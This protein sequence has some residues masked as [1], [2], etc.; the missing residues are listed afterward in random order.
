MTR[1]IYEQ[2]ATEFGLAARISMMDVEYGLWTG[3]EAYCAVA[4]RDNPKFDAERF[5]KWVTEVRDGERDVN[6]KKIKMKTS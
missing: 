6:G 1:K 3:I 4:K 5:N 2:M